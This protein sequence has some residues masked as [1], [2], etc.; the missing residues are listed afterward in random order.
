MDKTILL[1]TLFQV[2]G[3]IATKV[4]VDFKNSIVTSV[5]REPEVWNKVV[6]TLSKPGPIIFSAGGQD[7]SFNIEEATEALRSRVARTMHIFRPYLSL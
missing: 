4:T 7:V 2:N 1:R 5:S 3:R 6:A